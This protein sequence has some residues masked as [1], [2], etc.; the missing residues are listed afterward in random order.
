MA[1]RLLVVDDDPDAAFTLQALLE[2]APGA[3]ATDM[4]QV[5]TFEEGLARATGGGFDVLVFDHRLGGRT[6]LELIEACGAQGVT[7]PIIVLT[8]RGDEQVAVQAMKSG[9][10]DYLVKH[11]LTPEHLV[12]SLRHAAERAE[13]ARV[14]RQA[15]DLQRASEEHLRH[16]AQAA[17]DTSWVMD[18]TTGVTR[19]SEPFRRV[20][21]YALDEIPQGPAWWAERVHPDDR[22][23]VTTSFRGLA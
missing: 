7:A 1:L 22:E 12:T 11:R 23:R 16:V 15:E 20:F 19:V 2:L 4:A 18:L 13:R 9:A 3:P 6:G 17:S 8:G 21:G 14:T 5:T 10:V